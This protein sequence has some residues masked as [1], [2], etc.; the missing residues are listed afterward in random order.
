MEKLFTKSSTKGCPE[1]Y[2]QVRDQIK[3]GDII[4]YRGSSFLAKAIRFFDNC[5]YNHVGIA[6]VHEESGR[7]LTLDMWTGGLDFVPLSR[8]MEGYQDFCILRPKKSMPCLKGAIYDCLKTWDGR[9]IEYD[10]FLLLRIAIWKKTGINLTCLGSSK[11]YVCSEFVREEYTNLLNYKMYE[12][13]K[14]ITPE[15]FFRYNDGGLEV[16]L[17]DRKFK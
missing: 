16:L 17:D 2:S 11:K 10:H 12:K 6:Y 5:Y 3:T 15:D 14:L 1:K 4:L 13:I 9:N 8:R 7:V